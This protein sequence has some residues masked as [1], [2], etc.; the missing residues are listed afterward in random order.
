MRWSSLACCLP[1]GHFVMFLAIQGRVAM[2]LT[3]VMNG[4]KDQFDVE[5]HVITTSVMTEAGGAPKGC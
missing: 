5:V 1:T 3:P 4:R 2:M